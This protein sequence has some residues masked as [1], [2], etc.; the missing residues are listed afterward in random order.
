MS[1]F[2]IET[3]TRKKNPNVY[4]NLLQGFTLRGDLGPN[5][6]ERPQSL[7]NGGILVGSVRHELRDI[8]VEGFRSAAVDNSPGDPNADR[9]PGIE[10][11][12]DAVG[13][14]VHNCAVIGCDV[15]IYIN[16][17]PSVRTTTYLSF[18][19][20][21][22]NRTHALLIHRGVGIEVSNFT[23]EANR[24]Q[25]TVL[26]TDE[27]AHLG[28]TVHLRD[29][30]FENNQ[31]GINP[32]DPQQWNDTREVKV[33]VAQGASTGPHTLMTNVVAGGAYY[34]IELIHCS[35]ATFLHCLF[36]PGTGGQAPVRVGAGTGQTTFIGCVLGRPPD[37]SSTAVS[38]T[39]IGCDIAQLAIDDA[40]DFPTG[41]SAPSAQR[42]MHFR[43]P[44]GV[45]ITDLTGVDGAEI[46][47]QG[48][49][50]QT[51]GR[52]SGKF[53]FSG[54][55]NTLEIPEGMY[56]RLRKDPRQQGRWT[57]IGG[58]AVSEPGT[59]TVAQ[60]TLSIDARKV[61][62]V[63]NGINTDITEI[64]GGHNMQEITIIGMQTDGSKITFRSFAGVTG[65]PRKLM[66]VRDALI[67]SGDVL[68]LLC[69]REPNNGV[70]TWYEVSRSQ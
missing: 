13:I 7:S 6:T 60:N 27:A 14:R 68:T 23:C 15:G 70:E 62:E 34:P 3:T 43:L 67:G 65:S 1:A 52:L 63:P 24:G 39:F 47:V 56:V 66:L 30:W 42:G 49:Q 33:A 5:S 2:A 22:E 16:G 29:G 59:V 31:C 18:L 19:H 54:R 50:G 64:S 21:R 48:P 36:V 44:P 38:T 46:I 9:R 32:N 37:K 25:V 69:R 26:I 40:A 10:I 8:Y 35:S 61:W 4:E 41:Y 28:H 20:L 12:G 45:T 17:C 58:W 51:P 55:D 57:Q 53:L 11:H